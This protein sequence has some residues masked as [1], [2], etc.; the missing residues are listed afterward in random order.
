M[1]EQWNKYDKTAARRHG[2]PGREVRPQSVTVDVHAHVGV[3]KRRNSSSRIWIGQPFRW[4][5]S[6]MPR[7]RR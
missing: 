2:K 6:P 3:P 1:T 5:I 4:R 7:P